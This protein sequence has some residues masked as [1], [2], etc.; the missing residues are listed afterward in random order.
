[1]RITKGEPTQPFRFKAL[2][3]LC[4]I[5]GYQA[6]AEMFGVHI[7]GFPAWVMWRGVYLLKLPTWSRRIK[8]ALDWAWDVLFPRDLSS[9]L[10]TDAGPAGYARVLQARWRFYSTRG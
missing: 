4:S 9:F 8:V 7:S 5:G 3:Q 10:N 1:M 2:G 6:V